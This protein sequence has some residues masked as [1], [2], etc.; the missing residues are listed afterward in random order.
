MGDWIKQ[1]AGGM[2]KF[3]G[4]SR[5]VR[6]S[7]L[8]CFCSMAATEPVHAAM[9]GSDQNIGSNGRSARRANL[10]SRS[11]DVAARFAAALGLARAHQSQAALAAFTALLQADSQSPEIANNLAVLYAREGNYAKARDLLLQVRRMRPD[12]ALAVRNLAQVQTAL[13]AITY[14]QALNDP[15]HHRPENLTSALELAVLVEP[16]S[17]APQHPP[18]PV[19]SSTNRTGQP[20][21]KATSRQA[22]VS[23]GSAA[24][25]VE[26]NAA[27]AAPRAK[28]SDDWLNEGYA[29]LNRKDK[30]A[31]LSA[32]RQ[33]VLLAPDN[34]EA[35]KNIGYA[36]LDADRKAAALDDFQHA[37]RLAPADAETLKNIGY[38]QID[39]GD[40]PAALQAFAE[41]AKY[42]A[43]DVEVWTNLAYLQS[44]LG[45]KP[46]ALN[47]FLKAQKLK[48]DNNEVSMEI[49]YL[50]S[51]LGDPRAA[52]R[53][54]EA[55]QNNSHDA[56]MVQ[57]AC[58]GA[59]DAALA[60]TRLL[61]SPNF[62]DIYF[63]PSYENT[64]YT[65]GLFPFKARLGRHFGQNDR[66]SVYG[67]VSAQDDT[68]SSSGV[69]PAILNDNAVIA[70]GGVDYRPV[71]SWP[72]TV[73]AEA[74]YGYDLTERN[75][76]RG[77]YSA[78]VGVTGY[79]AWGLPVFACD[80]QTRW[81]WKPFADLYGD[82]EYATRQE[83]DVLLQLRPR[84][85]VTAARGAW[86][87]AELYLKLNL[88]ADS[89]RLYYN[90]LAEFGPGVAWQS[91]TTI[92]L[93]LRVEYVWGRYTVNAR[94]SPT[95]PS[96]HGAR[97]EL[98]FYW[99]F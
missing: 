95:G 44:G 26:E 41:A 38:L 28:S 82:V 96:Y 36:D 40:K 73:Y 62:G 24:A 89:K 27:A 69:Q 34:V 1:A 68:G 78:E 98:D 74:G 91:H 64:R 65:D 45:N 39:R 61:S 6:V 2:G 84:V 13:A 71:E 56:A 83:D 52:R 23:V 25:A 48:P 3:R 75:R 50:Q 32:F 17:A 70:G 5:I 67:F 29:A 20:R 14:N 31:A 94:Q 10:S 86:G 30:P 85:G 33:A 51:S 59:H 22:V 93:V 19:R 72:I 60:S 87:S 4:C 11:D 76:R 49:A 66:G 90:N 80:S 9:P 46:E 92:P 97:A 99:G 55:V 37:S 12:Y 35:W 88:L 63:A 15:E 58:S 53:Q 77:R 57:Q 16:P 42:Q 54:F 18:A 21:A 7:M 8:F 47:D 79:Q 81:L 43:D